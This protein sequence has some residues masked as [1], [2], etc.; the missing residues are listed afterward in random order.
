MLLVADVYAF[1]IILWEIVTRLE[2]Y[3]D[4]APMQI[5]LEVVSHDLRPTIPHAFSAS[6]LVPL[7]KDCWSADPGNRPTFT[8]I[9]ARLDELSRRVEAQTATIPRPLASKAAVALLPLLQQLALRN[10]LGGVV[11]RR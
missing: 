4:K 5:I 6:P 2:P 7:M 11:I 9:L 1:G 10:S 3:E 8:V